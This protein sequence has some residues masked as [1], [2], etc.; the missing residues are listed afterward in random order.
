MRTSHLPTLPTLETLLLSSTLLV[1]F[2]TWLK[3]SEIKTKTSWD[4]ISSPNF[5]NLNHQ[6]SKAFLSKNFS[7]WKLNPTRSTWESRLENKS[8]NLSLKCPTTPIFISFGASN[9]TNKKK[10]SP[11]LTEFLTIKSSIWVSWTPFRWERKATMFEYHTHNSTKNME[12][13]KK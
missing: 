11:L 13:S 12:S 2:S 9:P 6:L 3:G 8:R 5:H 7:Q 4:K 10:L 1:K